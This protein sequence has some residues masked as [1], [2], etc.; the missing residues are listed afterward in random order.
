MSMVWK[1]HE[2]PPSKKAKAI[3][4]MG[5][6]MCI[7]FLDMRGVVLEHMVKHGQTVNADYYSKVNNFS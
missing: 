3:K 4:S 6:V 7:V 1:N 5:K 2:S